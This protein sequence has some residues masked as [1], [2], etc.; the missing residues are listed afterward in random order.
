MQTKW[1]IMMDQAENALAD[2]RAATMRAEAA[3]R[4][5][6]GLENT[7]CGLT[8]TGCDTFLET[9][10]DFA[11]HFHVPDRRFK[12]LGNCPVAAGK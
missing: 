3:F 2:A 8:C 12:N 7:P 11:K 5:L 6:R 9:E 10:A 4:A 1:T